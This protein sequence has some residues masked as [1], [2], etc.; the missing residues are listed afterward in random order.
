MEHKKIDYEKV[1]N[2]FCSIAELREELRSPFKQRE[3][4]ASTDA[5]SM[6]YMPTSIE[7]LPFE[8]QNITNIH[9]VIPLILHEE[10][11]LDVKKLE[12]AI[13]ELT[14]LID[15]W[16]IVYTTCLECGGDGVVICDLAH[17]HDCIKCKGSGEIPENRLSELKIPDVHTCFSFII[18][19]SK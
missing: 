8:E 12:D 18:R 14:P 10:I 15:E 3:I 16:K 2:M 9:G 17:E 6:I 7:W 1:F 11:P 13:K 5:N 4:Y 19:K